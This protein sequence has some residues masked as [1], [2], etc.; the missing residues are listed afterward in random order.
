MATLA[1]T[2]SNHYFP[3]TA[4]WLSVVVGSFGREITSAVALFKQVTSYI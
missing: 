1:P 3:R 2:F 4:E